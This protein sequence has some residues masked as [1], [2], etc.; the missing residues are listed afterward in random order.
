MQEIE[1]LKCS[2][3]S[4]LVIGTNFTFSEESECKKNF[5]AVFEIQE[6]RFKQNF[7][8]SS[9]YLLQTF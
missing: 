9:Q 7:E 4:A 1:T 6:V 5:E 3:E 2:V 8:G